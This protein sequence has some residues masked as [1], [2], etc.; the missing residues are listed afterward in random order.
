MNQ[1]E[2]FFEL[3]H[4]FQGL[5]CFDHLTMK[6][7][8]RRP[9]ARDGRAYTNERY[10]RTR[11]AARCERARKLM[12]KYGIRRINNIPINSFVVPFGDQLFHV[13]SV[14]RGNGKI[15]H[16]YISHGYHFNSRRKVLKFLNTCVKVKEDRARLLAIG[17]FAP[18]DTHQ[19]RIQKLTQAKF[20]M[21]I[22]DTFDEIARKQGTS[23]KE[24]LLNGHVAVTYP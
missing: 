4:S 24:M 15:D 11:L 13:D 19:E 23:L 9:N 5:Y 8:I 18:T 16:Y 10:K 22:R 20:D 1:H 21:A 7:I 12:V 2:T 14:A 6:T 17:R 3:A